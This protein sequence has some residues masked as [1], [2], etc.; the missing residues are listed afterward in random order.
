[1][2]RIFVLLL[3]MVCAFALIGCRNE[4]KIDYGKSSIYTKDDMDAAIEVIR[5]EF[6]NFDGCELHSISYSSDRECNKSNISWMNELREDKNVKETFTQC[7][8][9]KS[10]FHSPKDGGGAWNEDYEYIDWEWWL[11]RSDNGSWK[12]MTFG[13][14]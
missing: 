3:S 9:F 8:M 6:N 13:F 7:I 1:M 14:G 2:K 4:V 10:N 12:V 11:A 5:K